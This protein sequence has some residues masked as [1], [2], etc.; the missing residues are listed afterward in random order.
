M[1]KVA[2]VHSQQMWEYAVVNRKT[3]EFLIVELNELGKAGWELVD[4]SF[5]KDVKGVAASF[6]WTAFLKR[7]LVPATNAAPS[8]GAAATAPV[9]APAPTAPPAFSGDEDAGIFDVR[10]Q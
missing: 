6:S 4:T 1:T 5:N 8:A 10:A 2:T 3:E 7:P 9:P